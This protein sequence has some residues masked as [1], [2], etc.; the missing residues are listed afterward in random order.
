MSS[1]A[2]MII[3]NLED[4]Q[5][6]STEFISREL[7]EVDEFGM[8]TANTVDYFVARILYVSYNLCEEHL[9]LR[10]GDI[11][12]GESP[13]SEDARTM[14][15]LLRMPIRLQDYEMMMVWLRLKQVLPT[16]SDKV[17]VV[18]KNLV[19]DREKGDL[20]RMKCPTRI[21]G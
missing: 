4:N 6:N 14:Y 3:E 20:R 7:P 8:T 1:L 21:R 11:W 13:L 10:D 18:N 2:D 16:L 9:H 12:E 15:R 5:G 19:Y 17:F